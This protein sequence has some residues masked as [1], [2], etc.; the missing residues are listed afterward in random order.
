VPTA[1]FE[2]LP[3]VKR[4]A[5]IDI[6]IEEFGAHPYNAASVSRIVARAGIAKGSVY[7]YF[8]DKQDFFLYLLAYA[9]QAQ[10]SLL[11]NLPPPDQPMDFFAT[12][13]WQMSASVRVGVQAPQLV[14]LLRRAVEGNLPF[15]PEVERILGRAGEEHFD[16]L[17]RAARLRGEIAPDLDLEL[18]A[19]LVQRMTGELG[20]FILRRLGLTPDDA[21]DDIAQ[22]DTPAVEAI[23]DAVISI[24][25][26]GLSAQNAPETGI[27]GKT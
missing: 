4:Q 8:Q 3:P 25:R 22:L 16:R 10:L 5:I 9:T 2:N 11:A 19:Y 24:L 12:L 27:G 18:A 17:L 20:F 7:Q 1:T 15:Q 14:R 26:S 23:Y 21:V 13:R 6:A